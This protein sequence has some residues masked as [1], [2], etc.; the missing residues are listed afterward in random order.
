MNRF[1]KYY[2]FAFLLIFFLKAY[3]QPDLEKFKRFTVEDGL[4][5]RSVQCIEQ[6]KLGY[7]WFGTRDGL[8]R[9]DGYSFQIF[10]PDLYP[11]LKSAVIHD[12]HA[13]KDN[14]LWISTAKGVYKYSQS[15]GKLTPVTILP[16]IVYNFIFCDNQNNFWF[17][18]DSGLFWYNPQKE[19]FVRFSTYMPGRMKLNSNEIRSVFQDSEQ[20]IWI[21]SNNGLNY[22]NLKD[23]TIYNVSDMTGESYFDRLTINNIIQDST[24]CLWLAATQEA[25]GL[26]SFQP[27]SGKKWI[28]KITKHLDQ[29][30]SCLLLD[31]R[32]ILWVG[33]VGGMGLQK[34][35]LNQ[36]KNEIK[37]INS[38]SNNPWDMNSLSDNSIEAIF[39]DSWGD[40]WIGTYGKG[41]NYLNF[42]TKKFYNENQK[43]FNRSSI[44]N[45]IVNCFIE[46]SLY[47]WV[48]TEVGLNRIEK[49]TGL[50]RQFANDP[51]DNKSLGANAV[52]ALCKDSKGNLWIGSWNGGVNRYNYKNETFI[53]YKNQP[54]N[55]TSLSKNNVF[56]IF[57]DQFGNLWVGTVGGGL[58]KFDYKTGTFKHYLNDPLDNNSL[59]YNY[60][61]HIYQTQN[62]ELWISTYQQINR[63]DYE[64]ETFVKYAHH[65][66]DSNSLTSGDIE[67]IF[68]DSNE[69]LWIG[70]AGGLNYFDRKTG[71]VRRF[72][73]RDGLPNS[74]INGIT[75]DGKGNLWISTTLG[76]SKMEKG[77]FLPYKPV[78][79]NFTPE[80]GIQGY[81]FVKRSVYRSADGKIYFGGT[82]GYTWF[83]PDS[84]TLDT[85]SYP[86]HLSNFLLF[87]KPIHPKDKSGI[88]NKNIA[89]TKDITLSH[90]QSVFSIEYTT[91]NFLNPHKCQFAYMLDGFEDNWNY[92]EN[93]RI[94]TY[95]NI[96]AGKYTFR[97]KVTNGDGI[98]NPLEVKL[99]IIILPPWWQTIW[100]RLL[101]L[102]LLIGIIILIYWLRYRSLMH[103]KKLLKRM[104]EERTH[105]LSETNAVLEETKEEMTIQN[106]ELEKHRNNLENL[107]EERTA[108][109]Q[110]ALDKAEESDRLK[111]AFLANLSH[112]IRT[113]MNAIVGFSSLLQQ[114]DPTNEEQIRF[115]QTIQ[116]NGDMLLVLINDILDISLIEAKQLK[117]EKS[118]FNVT[119]I[120]KELE[121]FYRLNNENPVTINFDCQLDQ[122]D[123]Y[124]ES[125][126]VRF[127][128][129]MNNLLNNSV[130]FTSK[131]T[132]S[133]GCS[134]N[135]D[136]IRFFVSDTG[137]GINKSDQQ[138]IFEQFYRAEDSNTNTYRGTGLGLA[139]S[140]KLVELMG[141]EIWVE[142]LPGE[143]SRFYFTLPY[144]SGISNS[145]IELP[146][147]N[148]KQVLHKKT[149][150]LVVEDE[151]TN[152]AL[153]EHI[154]LKSGIKVYRASTGIEAIHFIS[155]KAD[156]SELIVLMDIK[157]PEMNG[158]QA[159][160]IIRK[161]HQDL[162]VIAVTAYATNEDK[163]KILNSGFTDYLSKPF[164][165]Q[166]LN[167]LIS[168]YV[169]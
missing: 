161:K 87:N 50:I 94:A 104:V 6:D 38:Y 121:E 15:G 116:R 48:G 147:K 82:N 140:K 165:V 85:I 90:H 16:D 79:Q 8:N 41:V 28:G 61:D 136:T 5:Q 93:R 58:N 91:V 106:E 141:G 47:F 9:F 71:K 134:K 12:L 77:T 57:E 98:W 162:P 124:L 35:E 73:T 21:G 157:M 159:I 151:D 113:P 160:E 123:I 101:A 25:G 24:G 97:L 13:D 164:K 102:V 75:E 30:V 158:Y 84:I 142:S 34:F 65:S 76:L 42:R 37:L 100:F 52:Y 83:Y 111:S 32:N 128:Q 138:R 148:Q 89:I 66:N 137:I 155:N 49:S 40:I 99:N 117:I 166:D 46:D 45:N 92:V 10:R 20:N 69:H 18:S 156:M 122:K 33:R 169:K 108:E 146:K 1:R 107:V 11:S 86:L 70:T 51:F 130:K 64:T 120:L 118:I 125:D 14:N 126:A 95:T 109:L 168:K 149:S 27:S 127:K 54:A 3:S 78:F 68:E 163:Q 55:P 167:Q 29:N 26:Y 81:E 59:G 133:V 19:K 152:Y 145:T 62:G 17:G 60:V 31:C 132:I 23:S 153:A 154:L 110:L 96:P 139:I 115:I 53:R 105:Q 112:E 88:L 22:F 56:S 4:S 2:T 114:Q 135:N 67:I 7:I 72:T 39:E 63:F 129:V 143:G 80:D 36:Q 44:S 131:G 119:E 144:N 103:Q 43:Q 150:V 74:Y